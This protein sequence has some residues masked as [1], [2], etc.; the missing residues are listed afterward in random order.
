MLIGASGKN[1]T[2]WFRLIHFQRFSNGFQRFSQIF[3]WFSKIFRN[4]PPPI[5]QIPWKSYENPWKSLK[6]SE[7]LW[8]SLG[9][10]WGRGK[11]GGDRR[12]N[13]V[14]IK[15]KRS[16]KI[17]ENLLK[18]SENLWKSSLISS[19]NLKKN[20]QNLWRYILFSNGFSL[21][22]KH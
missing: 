10:E 21:N 8:R 4:A 12:Q 2:V 1:Q 15:K 18:I 7:N 11:K 13:S 20:F 19:Q 14:A 16:Q 5:P 17:T 9:S 3:K 22:I 6:I